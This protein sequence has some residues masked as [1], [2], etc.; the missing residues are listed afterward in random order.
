M[1][2]NLGNLA[3]QNDEVAISVMGKERASIELSW[4][5]ATGDSVVF[6]AAS[7]PNSAFA[8]IEG[9][10]M[11]DIDGTGVT[12]SSTAGVWLFDVKGIARLR[13]RADAAPGSAIAVKI[14]A[15]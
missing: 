9:F 6:E 7:H 3:A 5:P 8:A 15:E 12:T 14:F 11:D 2:E 4:T 1:S 10:P 13:A